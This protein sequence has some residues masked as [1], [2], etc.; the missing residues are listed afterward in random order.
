[1]IEDKLDTKLTNLTNFIILEELQ[2]LDYVD[3]WPLWFL[4]SPPAWNYIFLII[5]QIGILFT[6]WLLEK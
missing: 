3:F 6:E 4:A 1:M 5:T 2:Y